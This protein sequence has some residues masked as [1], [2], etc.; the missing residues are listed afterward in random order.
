M[1]KLLLVVSLLVISVYSSSLLSKTYV[2]ASSGLQLVMKE[3]HQAFN[4]NHPD[5]DIEFIFASSG[6]LL[7]KIKKGAP[8][9][10]YLPAD[11]SYTKDFTLK[12]SHVYAYGR[13]SLIGRNLKTHSTRDLLV[14]AKRIAIAQPSHAPYGQRAKE[15]LINI[16]LWETLQKKM[17]FADNVAQASQYAISGN[18]DLAFSAAALTPASSPSLET[19]LVSNQHYSLLA[20][21]ALLLE[22]KD[23]AAKAFFNFLT[24]AQAQKI[25][26]KY[27]Y[28]L[29]PG[30]AS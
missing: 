14:S 7:S 3:L 20:Q 29:Q 8:Y 19:R 1:R 10:L 6:N 17:V 23:Q 4:E 30:K 22:P 18:C 12:P 27:G 24:S 2:A 9:S 28:L 11:L 15:F 25:L 21:K 26:I 13:I 16:G 5:Q